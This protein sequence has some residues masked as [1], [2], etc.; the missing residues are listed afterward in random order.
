MVSISGIEALYV[1]LATEI[2]CGF[3]HIANKFANLYH[4]NTGV[5]CIS[6]VDDDEKMFELLGTNYTSIELNLDDVANGTRLSEKSWDGL[7]YTYTNL[8]DMS[9]QDRIGVLK[10][11]NDRY[12]KLTVS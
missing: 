6:F 10:L 9:I 12:N 5:I 8:S 4:K 2:E 7:V 1:N 3:E 11:L